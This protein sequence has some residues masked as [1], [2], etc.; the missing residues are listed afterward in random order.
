MSSILLINSPLFREKQAEDD[1]DYLPPIGLGYIA[2]NLRKVGHAVRLIDA[3]ADNRTIPGLLE[4]IR[5]TTPDVIGLNVFTTNYSLV[6]EL[7]ESIDDEAM[8][9]LIGGLSTRTLYSDIFV[10]DS[11]NA[12]D[13]VCGDGELITPA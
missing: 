4:M 3:V 11:A 8:R 5:A 12:I 9:I 7:V 1:E 13:V 10:W 6:R 2:T